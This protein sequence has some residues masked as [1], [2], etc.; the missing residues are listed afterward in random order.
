[1]YLYQY[2][3]H[4]Q[5]QQHPTL[6]PP[7]LQLVSAPH[8]AG[9]WS[10]VVVMHHPHPSLEL[11]DVTTVLQGLQFNRYTPITTVDI[12]NITLMFRKQLLE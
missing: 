4:F 12:V 6:S 9:A 11:P 10:W 8:C 1:M 5:S 3:Q 7:R 2:F